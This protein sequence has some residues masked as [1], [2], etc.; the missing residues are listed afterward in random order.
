M[1]VSAH[2]RALTKQGYHV[3]PPEPQL[4]TPRLSLLQRDL[5]KFVDSRNE[6]AA[7]DQLELMDEVNAQFGQAPI[8]L[9]LRQQKVV[10]ERAEKYPTWRLLPMVLRPEVT[11]RADIVTPR[12]EEAKRLI[13]PYSQLWTPVEAERDDEGDQWGDLW[14]GKD[15]IHK[16]DRFVSE[17]PKRNRSGQYPEPQVRPYRLLHTVEGK[18][19]R[20]PDYLKFLASS[21]RGV[22]GVDRSVGTLPLMDV[23][24]TRPNSIDEDPKRLF[25]ALDPVISPEVRLRVQTL[26]IL[27]GTPLHSDV[28]H[29]TN[30]AVA[31][32]AGANGH[33]RRIAGVVGVTRSQDK[34]FLRCSMWSYR[35]LPDWQPSPGI[36]AL[37]TN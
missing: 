33:F 7:E 28:T 14:A 30:E 8:E 36:S 5:A 12:T 17:V 25:D 31:E 10:A 22:A 11:G 18:L 16:S 26:H 27:A 9:T 15:K 13:G 23:S 37:S 29:V 4:V 2:I 20:R 19:L 21:G 32:L 35:S 6:I 1:P 34:K 3:L 24:N